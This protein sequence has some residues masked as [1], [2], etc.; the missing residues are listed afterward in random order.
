MKLK[1]LCTIVF[2]LCTAML[3][4]VLMAQTPVI[5]WQETYGGSSLDNEGRIVP[6][7]DGGYIMVSYAAS[8]DGDVSG[9]NG[10]YDFWVVKVDYTGNIEWQQ[11]LGGSL[12]DY[13]YGVIQTTDG[14]YAVVGQSN[15]NDGDVSGNNGGADVWV[16]KLNATG[17]I[18]W[19]NS[20]GGS[21]NENATGIVQT[22]D[23]GYVVVGFTTSNDGDV[24]GNNGS[25]DVWVIK[26]TAS[27]NLQWQNALGGTNDEFG[28][29]I[30]QTA[31]GGYVAIGST[32][33]GNGDVSGN[34]GDADVWVVKLDA[35]GN[36][37]WQN[38]FGGTVSDQGR[39]IIQTV[40]G[41]YAISG[42]VFSNDGDVSGS[43]GNGD[44]WLAKLDATGNLL[45]QSAFGG[46]LL[47][48]VWQITQTQDGGFA[49]AAYTYSSDVDVIGVN[50]G[51][52]DAWLVKLNS[53]GAI[54]WQKLVGG[55][56]DDRFFSIV[57]TNDGSFALAG[58]TSSNDG[59]VSGNNGSFDA[60][61]VKLW[62]AC[63][64]YLLQDVNPWGTAH[65]TTA[66]N[67]VFGASGY[68]SV[69]YS[70]PAASIF[71]SNTCFVFMEG[72]R[73]NC[74]AFNSYINANLTTIQNWVA[75]GGS[76]YIN[77][78]PLG[79]GSAAP[80]FGG[81]TIFSDV[82]GA[83]T[84]LIASGFGIS[85][86]PVFDGPYTP[87]GL[88]YQGGAFAHSYIVGGV[89][90]TIFKSSSANNF[91]LAGYQSYGGGRLTI[92]AHTTPVLWVPSDGTN[93]IQNIIFYAGSALPFVPPVIT[94]IP[95]ASTSFCQG[96]SF[97][98]SFS[99]TDTTDIGNTYTA[100]LSDS[101]GSF[102]SPTAIGTLSSNDSVGSINVTI[103]LSVAPGSAYRIRV[104]SSN[105]GVTG[106]DNG[107]NL[108]I[109]T[110]P[111][112]AFTASLSCERSLTQFTNQSTISSGSIFSYQYQF[113]EGSTSLLKDPTFSYPTA[114]SYNVT[115]TITSDQGCAAVTSQN[116]TVQ[117][118]PIAG[119]TAAANVCQGENLLFTNTATG[120]N[121][122]AWN[123]G[124]GSTSAATSPTHAYALAGTYNVTLN[125]S[126]A[127][128]CAD[129][130]T[131][132]ITVNPNPTPNL[133]ITGDSLACQFNT[134][135]Y[136]AN[137]S[138]GANI[139][140]EI[141]PASA[142]N[143][144]TGHGTNNI[145]IDWDNTP[146]GTNYVKVTATDPITGCFTTDSLA[147][148]VNG[149]FVF[150]FANISDACAGEPALFQN[151][152]T[153]FDPN[154]TYFWDFGDS[155]TSNTFNP[156]HIYANA[157]TYS[158]RLQ[159]T[160]ELNCTG[161]SIF[162]HTVPAKPTP[163]FTF[164]TP[165]C[166]GG[167]VTF[168][169]TSTN[170]TGY[171]W[172]FGDGDTSTATNPTHAYA[173]A[174][175]YTV[176]LT[177]AATADCDAVITKSVTISANPVPNFSVSGDTLACTNL[178]EIY[179]TSIGSGNTIT[180]ALSGGGS[181]VSGQGT[182]AI[183]VDW[184]T[185]GS[186]FVKVTATSGSGCTTL[187]SLQVDI[188]NVINVAVPTFT[189]ACAGEVTQF[190]A[191]APA[192]GGPYTFFW[193]FADGATSTD[194]NPSHIFAIA[195][196]YAVTLAITSPANCTGTSTTNV[197][198][199]AKP[200]A[201]F[202][203][204][205]AC[206]GGNVT[207]TNNSSNANSYEWS[208]G[209]GA[210]SILANPT[211]AYA[212]AGTYTVTLRAI[213]TANCD[214]VITQSVTVSPR[215]VVEFT[216]TNA[217]PDSLVTF[218]NLS[219]VVSG[220]I[221]TY[222]W[223][224]GDGNTSAAA[225]PTH[226][227]TAPGTYQV[228]LVA[229]S[230]I[231][232]QDSIKHSVTI[233]DR[234]FAGFNANNVCDGETVIFTN[235]SSIGTGTLSFV[236]GFGDGS[237]STDINPTHL[238]LAAGTYNVT[239]TAT[240]DNGCSRTI[241]KPVVVNA[242]PT[243]SFTASATAI[244][245][246]DTITFTNSSSTG[247]NV[248]YNWDFGDG[249]F[250]NFVTDTQYVYAAA[251]NYTVTLEAIDTITFC[252]TVTTVNITVYEEPVAG[253]TLANVCDGTSVTFTNTS[254]I[255]TGTL[256]YLWS[257]GDG[258][259][260][261]DINP[262]HLYGGPGTYNVLITATSN[263][264]C[265]DTLTQQVTIHPE[266]VAAF[267]LSNT[268]ACDRDTV[269]MTNNSIVV[270]TDILYTWTFGDGSTSNDVSPAYVYGAPGTYSVVLTVTDTVTGCTNV[271]SDTVTIF[272]R[273]VP[274]FT[275]A[276]V[277]LG[278]AASFTNGTTIGVGT[279][280]Y[281]WDF[282]D[283]TFSTDINPTHGY[284]SI[285][286][287]TITLIVTTNNGCTDTV[288]RTLIV[289]PLPET[290]FSVGPTCFGNPTDFTNLTTIV[291]GT[292]TYLWNF[293]DGV[294]DT[295]ANP[296]HTYTV[297][298]NYTVTLTA[299]SDAGC[300]DVA[301]QVITVHP[302][303]T[304]SF[305]AAN[306]CEDD[307]VVFDNNSTIPYGTLTS[308]WDFGDTF[309]SIDQNPTYTYT[310]FGTFTVT[311]VSTSN[312]GCADTTTRTITVYPKPIV[313]F[314]VEDVCIGE[315]VVFD[316]ISEVPN[317]GT[318]ADLR[319][320]FGDGSVSLE[321]SPTHLYAA[322]GIYEPYLVVTS[323]QGCTDTLRKTVVVHE[324]PPAT[325][326]ALGPL[327][328]CDGGSVDLR[329]P[330]GQAG[331]EWSTGET[332]QTI[333]VTTSGTYYVTV[334]STFNCTN[335]DSIEVI[336]WT[337]PIANAGNDTTISKGY[338]AQLNGSGGA[339]YEWT[340]TESLSNPSIA[341]PVAKPLETTTYTLLVTDTNGCQDT[342]EVTVF[343]NED[344]LVQATNTLTPNGD[345]KNDFW[346]IINIETYPDVEVLI[347]DRWGTEVYTSKAY[348]N[349]WGGTYKDNKLPEG[350]Y[351]YVIRF[352]GSDRLYKGA[353]N[354]LR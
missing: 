49:V 178:N 194:Q 146:I 247:T 106:S 2:F 293:G 210:T 284:D 248:V 118:S 25:S 31:D 75:D 250:S 91:L 289:S 22:S 313:A 59:D 195:G 226:A 44:A 26:L 275:T 151:P 286:I 213:S 185:P 76:L 220:T 133:V 324:L 287:K 54:Q 103:P 37:Q 122:Y 150:S 68:S 292:N 311:L 219:T 38:A 62:P 331:Y 97:S 110:A 251:G 206:P 4:T 169:N 135:S 13:G 180:W 317:N 255:P 333:T 29:Q 304:A 125:A 112:A 212:V 56:G 204:T 20:Y 228:T 200:V 140:W 165:T 166:P 269:T 64:R 201:S 148:L 173:T 108:A 276:D 23:G 105:P 57:E 278:A 120:A 63:N 78:A 88:N 87:V 257:F 346:Y 218:T 343:V 128:G 61:M 82:S 302:N 51:S 174:G 349:D 42:I 66:M 202:V 35:F 39:D 187:D 231:G 104:V 290:D 6:T 263:N 46:T 139:L 298:G 8:S 162:S 328:F 33:S 196:T 24:S 309:T 137:I 32:Y 321:V 266:P 43:N 158:I 222:S 181:I 209:D 211:H 283:S 214:A 86:H 36:F 143:I 325:I 344:Y 34:N 235:I 45:W 322:P 245:F 264:G 288:T 254:T 176:T 339:D 131:Q 223:N 316:N 9:N 332:T 3:G 301:S 142:A 230:N 15:S 155:N 186:Y 306:V 147:V 256:S 167:D 144:V 319:W 94:T 121:N 267:T 348:N 116:V 329:A 183:E 153:A 41:R 74:S 272:H 312:N 27:G 124:D 234:P 101:L 130:A 191:N 307:N 134:F 199:P 182:N 337:L 84:T 184:N 242:T 92:S 164:T 190:T 18:I 249:N 19:Q 233:Y 90:D 305:T 52:A 291:F 188:S 273:A 330:A 299:T 295:A 241:T 60:W 159:I 126:N 216:A 323:T 145:T 98:V 48:D 192:S 221:T 350:T 85:G 28:S 352:E 280:S 83:G 244:C 80:I 132:T 336:V 163:D 171:I 115:L 113:G 310:G 215:P 338:T 170:A 172:D 136:S 265:V 168:T 308:F 71:N 157:G 93:L 253:F 351:Y 99:A 303:P 300:V 129:T 335:T 271:A 40:D 5:Q 279:V 12:N 149:S 340:P 10:L 354:I 246:G 239:L 270:G 198:V 102:S 70:T 73:D 327:A 160:N 240:S 320:F 16:V 95:L 258:A 296:S 274:A 179:T 156:S 345:G 341:N 237:T 326:Q 21:L 96:S 353:V 207:F 127:T 205:P 77:Y 285:G 89:W 277:C 123:F 141:V 315:L 154:Y 58:H 225:N 224:F 197:V 268:T 261:T 111:S 236:W 53:T 11:S 67:S 107:T 30:R 297:L 227:Y 50:Q 260:S 79:C 262:T 314:D 114:G 217:C 177:A 81:I 119:F 138:S 117:A 347:F 259:T 175:T 229:T 193:N 100:Q 65:N 7:N 1:G 334:T 109:A 238:Y 17:G 203:A 252:A 281:F 294:T 208:F 161:T 72:S 189:R 282:G 318:I 69:G 55:S 342:D 14:G 243:A 47:D 232:C 152:A